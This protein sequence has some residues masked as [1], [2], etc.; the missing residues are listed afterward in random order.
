[1]P[2]YTLYLSDTEVENLS[3]KLKITVTANSLK[4]I[5][6]KQLNKRR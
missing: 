1:M 3:K 6:L 4:E 2:N 5:L